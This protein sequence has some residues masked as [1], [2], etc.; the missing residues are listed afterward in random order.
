M[1]LN[2]WILSFAGFSVFCCWINYWGGAEWIEGWKSWFVIGW[3]PS[4]WSAEQIKLYFFCFWIIG[5]IWFVVGLK[6][7][8]YRFHWIF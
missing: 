8:E 5:L 4:E 6:N 3:T 1:S 2:E 7:P